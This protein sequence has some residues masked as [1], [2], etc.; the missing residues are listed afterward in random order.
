M[1]DVDLHED[2]IP[3]GTQVASKART[4][5]CRGVGPDWIEHGV[6]ARVYDDVGNGY[7]DWSCGLGAVTIGH[8]WTF[9]EPPAC[10]PLP[11]RAELELAERLHEW[12]PCAEQMRFL[13]TGTDATSAA[14]RLARVYTGRERI[15]DCG[16]YHG[17]ADWSLSREHEGVPEAVRQ[18][19]E[20]VPYNDVESVVRELS[21]NDVAAVILEPV[22]LVSPQ[23]GYLAELRRVCTQFGAVLIYDEVITGIR[24]AKGGA[25]D[26]YGIVPDVACIGKGLANG[27]PISAVCGKRWLMECWN[28][29]HY[30]GTHFADP[31]CMR[32][33][34]K[35]TDYLIRNNFWDHQ[36]LVG[37]DMLG[38]TRRLIERSGLQ[39]V[40]TAAG[41]PHWWVLQIPDPVHQ[42]LFQSVCIE[43]GVLGSNGSHFVSLAHTAEIVRETLAVYELAFEVLRQAIQA[44]DA[45]DRLRCDVN[46]VTFRRS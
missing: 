30:S 27:Y 16:N 12:I 26:T 41:H 38:E 25:Q 6:G 35:T 36:F 4:R 44:G 21:C 9:N 45:A 29:T 7:I 42:T 15:I 33:A 28:R 5:H 32:A 20:R 34:M 37:G 23:P 43:R 10:L 17:C 22:S 3:Q 11:N 31:G 2:L 14:V 19:T 8:G 1:D 39:S 40:A 18:L 13:K 24:M 46:R